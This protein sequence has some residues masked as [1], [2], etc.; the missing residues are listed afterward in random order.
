M[1]IARQ[2]P[3]LSARVVGRQPLLYTAGPDTSLDRPV[4]VRAASAIARL[5]GGRLAIVQD[6]A[7][8]IALLDARGHVRDVPL[9]APDGIRLFDT[10]RGNKG[11]KLDLEA[12]VVMGER[13]IAFGSG[14]TGARERVVLFDDALGARVVHAH[15]LYGALRAAG[16]FS[17]SELNI[18]GAARHEGDIV[19]FQRGNGAPHGGILPV[20]ATARLEEQA[21]LAYLDGAG[22]CPPIASITS[23][24]LGHAAR[25][26]LTFTDAAT[27]PR[28]TLAFLACAEDTAD[29]IQDG[30]VSGVALGL[31]DD[32]AGMARLTTV[33]DE[34]ERPLT[35]KGEG[36]AFESAT[37]AF[38]VVDKDDP[39][40]PSEMLELRID[41]FE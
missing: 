17:G 25:V 3:T 8:F 5:P 33:L 32:R 40:L 37:R 13:L 11:K 29:A 24:D 14:S 15:E 23:W 36:L 38:V 2:D 21:L 7:S 39:S 27:T 10:T 31:L 22:P 1:K 35:D 4:H 28:G 16:A 30:P 18:E 26:R 6:D 9:P 19:L 34:Q 41:G 20:N 12:C